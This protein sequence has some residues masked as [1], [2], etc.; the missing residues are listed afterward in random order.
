MNT[1][2][3]SPPGWN[4]SLWGKCVFVSAECRCI[5]LQFVVVCRWC[6][7]Y[8]NDMFV[9]CCYFDVNLCSYLKEYTMAEEDINRALK[10]PTWQCGI[11]FGKNSSLAVDGN[12]N[13]SSSGINCIVTAVCV[14]PWWA[15]D[16][17]HSYKVQR[18]RLVNEANDLGEFPT[19][20]TMAL[21]L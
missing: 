16:L 21:V 6:L 11:A 1:I 7:G 3:N 9:L 18:V 20:T 2:Y 15:V 19:L 5:Y 17:M 8:I 14:Y 12:Y 13:P 10:K 4:V